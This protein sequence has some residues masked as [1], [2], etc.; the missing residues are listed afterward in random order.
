MCQHRLAHLTR[1]GNSRTPDSA[2]SLPR[3]SAAG[4]VVGEQPVHAIEQRERLRRGVM[5]LTASVISEADAVEIAQPWPSK[6]MSRDLA[7]GHP[8]A[9]AS[10]GRRTAD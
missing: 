2:A 4:R 10:G 9:A 8:A 7:V 6:R 1:A 3:S 5:P